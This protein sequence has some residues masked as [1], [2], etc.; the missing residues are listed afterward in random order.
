[1]RIVSLW[2]LLV[3]LKKQSGL[4]RK[5]CWY[6]RGIL[7]RFGG[8]GRWFSVH[9]VGILYIASEERKEV[10][11]MSRYQVKM[12]Q[13]GS[14]RYYYICDMDSM[15]IELYPSKYL[16]HKVRAKQ[17]PNTIRRAALA[18]AYYLQYIDEQQMELADVY[19]LGFEQQYK[20]FTDFLDWLK[21]GR[22]KEHREKIPNNG[23]CN[24]YLQDVFRFYLFMEQDE[25]RGKDLLVLSYNQIVTADSVGVKKVLRS[26][27][28]RGY[29][30]AEER[31]VRA[32]GKDEIKTLLEA[33][34]NCRD[35]AL[36]LLM[37]ETGF[38]IGEIL[39]I[40][41]IHDIDYKNHLVKVSFRED[42]ENNARA[43]NA[44]YRRAKI[45]DNTFDFLLYYISEY[46]HL[47]QK[48]RH[49]FITIAGSTA[50]HPMNVDAVYDMLE[51]M[52]KKTGVKT[53]PHMLRRY[54]G[55]ER[56]RAGWRL[57]MISHAYGHKHLETTVR[58]LNAIDDRLIEASDEF[59][60]KNAALYNVSQ[61]M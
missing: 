36:I 29:L 51:R 40:D 45:S 56:W 9:G 32:A 37:A 39:G 46:R 35:Q 47:I 23:T 6:F 18:L 44:E 31:N 33:C 30:K 52:E 25:W 20:H 28:F 17:S 5:V 22:H 57:E 1:M 54:F 42:N 26:Q 3:L 60:E 15:D 16:T 2:A 11:K 7:Q 58:Y 59:Y 48:Q 8:I 13:D 10:K 49:L 14:K 50:G 38:R 27:A 55:N 53:T 34:T 61:L 24:A 19:Q 43:K 12:Q 4:G 21:Q 41:Y